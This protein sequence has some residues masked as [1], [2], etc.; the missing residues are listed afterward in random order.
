MV[1]GLD[2]VVVVDAGPFGVLDLDRRVQ[3]VAEGDQ[4]LPAMIRKITNGRLAWA[5]HL[6]RNL[7]AFL[8]DAHRPGL[9][10]TVRP[11]RCVEVVGVTDHAARG[12]RRP[13]GSGGSHW[14]EDIPLR[15]CRF[16][17]A[18]WRGRWPGGRVRAHPERSR[19]DAG[20]RGAWAAGTPRRRRASSRAAFPID[21]KAVTAY[22]QHREG[23]WIARSVPGGFR[24]AGNGTMRLCVIK[25]VPA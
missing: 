8:D 6:P 10:P 7:M 17:A 15:W 4:P 5:G 2:R 11:C 20:C 12:R 25:Q 24:A 1:G 22:D 9:L 14:F 3:G 19:S 13:D 21:R 16:R 18:R 23:R